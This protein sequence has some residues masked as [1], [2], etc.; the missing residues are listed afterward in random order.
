[1]LFEIRAIQGLTGLDESGMLLNKRKPA[2]DSIE[3]DAMIFLSLGHSFEQLIRAGL[4]GAHGCNRKLKLRYIGGELRNEI[5]LSTNLFH[6]SARLAETAVHLLET[7]IHLIETAVHLLAHPIETAVR[8]LETPV[9]LLAHFAKQVQ[10]M[11][12]R[13]LSHSSMCSL[14][15]FEASN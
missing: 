14:R 4:I 8:F 2:V 3:P 11:I 6:L 9:R 12:F 5:R 10:R 13:F 1:M 7:A 15:A